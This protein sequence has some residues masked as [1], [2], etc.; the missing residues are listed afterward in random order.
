[1]AGAHPTLRPF[2]D[3][4]HLT[5]GLIFAAMP[6]AALS[7]LGFDAI[8]TLSEE[9]RGGPPAVARATILALAVAAALFVA[10]TW[11]ASL[12]VLHTQRFAP[13]DPTNQAFLTISRIVGGPAFRWM[14]SIL[15]VLFGGVAAALVAQAA[16]ARLL[17]GMARDGRLPRSL[18]HVHADRKVPVRAALVVAAL[19]LVLGLSLVSQLE[20]LLTVVSFGALTGFLMLHVS[21]ITYFVWRGRSRQL[22]RHLVVPLIGIAIIGYVLVS[23]EI[24]AKVVGLVWMSVGAAVML[25]LKLSGRLPA[26]PAG[27]IVEA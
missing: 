12:F 4:A 9:A 27:E 25:A 11:L 14:I 6:V 1:V 13:G 20:L 3:P 23:A 16:A 18:A 5:P 19:T 10:Q 24:H 21:V 15:G 26:L 8:S 17:Y 2:A 22:I 7:F